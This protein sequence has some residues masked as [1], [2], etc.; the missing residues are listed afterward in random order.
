M[1]VQ[2]SDASAT[3]LNGLIFI[4][5]GFNG[6]ECLQSVECYSPANDQWNNIVSMR[7]RRSGVSIISHHGCI[8]AFGGFNGI[9]RLSSGEKYDPERDQW[10]DVAEMF[11]PRSNFAIEVGFFFPC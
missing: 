3:T 9:S 1:N 11:N 2:R 8:Y 10:S 4:V 6:T 7:H 5:G